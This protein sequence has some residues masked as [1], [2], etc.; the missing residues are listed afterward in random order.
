ME[1]TKQS[2]SLFKVH[3]VAVTLDPVAIENADVISYEDVISYDQQQQC[4]DNGATP[5]ANED[6]LLDC[7]V[8]CC[9][10]GQQLTFLQISAYN[11]LISI[12]VKKYILY[13]YIFS[14]YSANPNTK[15]QI[16]C[17]P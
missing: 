17:C 3:L 12:T 4:H 13:I 10:R 15:P 2:S 9:C 16:L 8:S 6:Q 1:L 14:I 7:F 11:P 5:S